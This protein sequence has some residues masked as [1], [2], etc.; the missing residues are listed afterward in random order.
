MKATPRRIGSFFYGPD[1]AVEMS[2]I[3]KSNPIARDLQ[4]SHLMDLS[5]CTTC[6]GLTSRRKSYQYCKCEPIPEIQ[7]DVDCPNGYV[8]CQ[9]CAQD[10]AG[11]LSRFSWLVCRD[12][13]E[14]VNSVPRAGRSI[15]I[16]RH[17]IMNGLIWPLDESEEKAEQQAKELVA[18]VESQI[19]LAEF[20]LL[21]ARQLFNSVPELHDLKAVSVS[22]WKRY[23]PTSIETS[24]WAISKYLMATGRKQLRKR[25]STKA[26]KAR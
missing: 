18:F 19:T 26:V 1:R 15:P 10:V 12:C 16:G 7:W 17:S 2:E 22:D 13:H 25:R 3:V 6:F 23:F 11:G 4:N 24:R 9:L 8:L 21:Q 14:Q 20:G 5:V